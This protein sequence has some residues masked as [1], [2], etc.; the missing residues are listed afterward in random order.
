MLNS[1]EHELYNVDK[2]LVANYAMLIN[3]KI[4][5]IENVW[6]FLKHFSVISTTSE[7]LKERKVFKFQPFSFYWQ[8][9]FHAQM[10]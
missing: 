5:T 2:L 7:V 8:L 6:H 3:V 10:G 1:T 4:P 9:K